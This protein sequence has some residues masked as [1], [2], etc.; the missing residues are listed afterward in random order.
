MTF[1]SHTTSDFI[2]FI[3]FVVTLANMKLTWGSRG[4]TSSPFISNPCLS[5][6]FFPTRSSDNP[7]C[8]MRLKQM[9]TQSIEQKTERNLLHHH[10]LS[11]API[12]NA[13]NELNRNQI[14]CITWRNL[15]CEFANLLLHYSF[16][17]KGFFWAFT[18]ANF[19]DCSSPA[20]F[21]ERIRSTRRSSSFRHCFGFR[22][23][24]FRQAAEHE[25]W[26]FSSASTFVVA[27]AAP[28]WWH[29]FC[30]KNFCVQFIL[31]SL[32]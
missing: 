12:A 4:R 7:N 13:L 11:R 6:T 5:T 19:T 18:S 27:T 17:L 16:T 15:P 23:E 9:L 3:E 26:F 14:Y 20:I 29:T 30:A 1:S 24:T 21:G 31:V 32:L 22:M 25:Y 10:R 28:E 8:R 2:C